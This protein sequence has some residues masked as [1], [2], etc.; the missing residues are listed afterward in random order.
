[1]PFT[2]RIAI[3]E[4]TYT[5]SSVTLSSVDNGMLVQSKYICLDS[6]FWFRLG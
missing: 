4:V 6:L 5:V 2:A 3:S 1:M